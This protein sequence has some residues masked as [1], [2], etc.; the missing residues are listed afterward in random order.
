MKMPAKPLEARLETGCRKHFSPCSGERRVRRR[1]VSRNLLSVGII[2]FTEDD[3]TAD[4]SSVR[5]V[6]WHDNPAPADLGPDSDTGRFREDRPRRAD[7][8]R[9]RRRDGTERNDAVVVATKPVFF[10]SSEAEFEVRQVIKGSWKPG[11]HR[12]SVDSSHLSPA[13]EFVAF[14]DAKNEWRFIA[15]PDFRQAG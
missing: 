1:N 9:P 15:V 14:V 3:V 5:L 12:V 7:L 13:G 11:K 4:W 6:C 2:K 8:Y 10:R